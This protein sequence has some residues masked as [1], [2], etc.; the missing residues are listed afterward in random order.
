MGAGGCGRP[1]GSREGEG[2]GS[3]GLGPA[4]G[5]KRL[6]QPRGGRWSRAGRGRGGPR[7]VASLPGA[8][9]R[10]GRRPLPVLSTAWL[11]PRSR[12]SAQ[13]GRSPAAFASRPSLCGH[14]SVRA[15]TPRSDHGGSGLRQGHRV[16]PHHQ[17]LR[18]EAPLQWGS[19]PRQ[20][21]SGH[22]WEPGREPCSALSH[23]LRLAGRG[24]GAGNAR[25]GDE[26]PGLRV[27]Y[28]LSAAQGRDLGLLSDGLLTETSDPRG[29]LQ[30]GYWEKELGS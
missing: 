3:R 21:A 17:A 1:R 18:A 23:R 4:V 30:P 10:C 24:A 19:A 7:A 15:A 14:G 16:V 6:G 5:K 8:P 28:L 20:H 27:H 9:G 13:P 26:G 25:P 29:Q 11:G 12:V 22:R 2:C